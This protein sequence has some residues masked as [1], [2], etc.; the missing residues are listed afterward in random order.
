VQLRRSLGLLDVALF[1]LIACTNLQWVATAAAA[2]PSSLPVWLIGCLAMFIPVS[3][4]VMY[5][6][7]QYPEEG[8]MYVWSKRAFGPFG[9]FMT[10]W[11][12]WCSNLPYFPALLYFTAGNALF[13]AGGNS[14]AWS[15]SYD[16]DGSKHVGRTIERNCRNGETQSFSIQKFDHCQPIHGISEIGERSIRLWS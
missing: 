11:T 9:G 14:G 8:G 1:F 6:S 7:K 12:Y 3:V 2:G 15:K 16:H 10:G 13:I 4:A 5:L